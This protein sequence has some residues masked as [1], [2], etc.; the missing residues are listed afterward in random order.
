VFR[1]YNAFDLNE[2]HSQHFH[3]FPS[4]GVLTPCSWV[5]RPICH[6]SWPAG[7][8]QFG[9]FFI[10]LWYISDCPT[11]LERHR[12]SVES[13]TAKGRR[14]G[15]NFCFRCNFWVVATSTDAHLVQRSTS[16]G[17][18]KKELTA[19]NLSFNYLINLLWKEAIELDAA[20]KHPATFHPPSPQFAGV[21]L[22]CWRAQLH[23]TQIKLM[24]IK[25]TDLQTYIQ[26][27]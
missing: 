3:I 5:G 1:I 9:L 13:G 17:G 4:K 23:R 14:F 10:L 26:G 20:W 7:C 16:K 11:A 25:K 12:W 2:N 27:V 19:L 6:L 21:H 24:K 15:F 18:K 22:R 8:H